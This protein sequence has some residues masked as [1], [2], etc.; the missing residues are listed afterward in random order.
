MVSFI[1]ILNAQYFG[2]HSCCTQP[3]VTHLAPLQ[4]P[5][6][7][8]VLTLLEKHQTLQ[9]TY[10]HQRRYMYELISQKVHVEAIGPQTKK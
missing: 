9:E 8:F 5:L 1:S 2:S 4:G 6:L 7:L 3:L 10:L